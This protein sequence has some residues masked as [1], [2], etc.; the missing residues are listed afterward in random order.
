MEY[1]G[2][3]LKVRINKRMDYMYTFQVLEMPEEWRGKS[4]DGSHLFEASNGLKIVSC[5]FPT[6]GYDDLIHLRGGYRKDDGCSP[7]FEPFQ[8]DYIV[9]ALREFGATI[10]VNA[11]CD[12]H[13]WVTVYEGDPTYEGTFC[14]NCLT[15]QS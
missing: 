11:V 1:D 12:D 4:I 10:I 8:L 2:S 15:K 9:A 3:K 7:L 5:L 6:I 13:E 14:K